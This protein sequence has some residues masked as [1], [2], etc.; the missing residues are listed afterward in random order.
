MSHKTI[1]TE[2]TDVDTTSMAEG[3]VLVQQSGVLQDDDTLTV[4]TS[5]GRLGVG[6]ASPGQT[7]DVRGGAVFNEDS[8]SVDFRVEGN[9]D[10]H[11][12]FVDGSADEVGIGVSNPSAKLNIR[13]NGTTSATICL[14]LEDGGGYDMLRVYNNRRLMIQQPSGQAQNNGSLLVFQNDNFSVTNSNENFHIGL[15][16]RS[17]GD[18]QVH[19]FGVTSPTTSFNTKTGGDLFVEAGSVSTNCS[20]ETDGGF[21]YLR[22]GRAAQDATN[23]GDSNIYFQTSSSAGASQRGT[24]TTAMFINN[25]QEVG[26]GTVTP[27]ESLDINGNARVR[28][29]GS[30]ASVGALHYTSNGTLT[31]NT[32][33][34]RLK[35][36]VQPL[37]DSLK[38]IKKLRGVSFDWI[39]DKDTSGTHIG[40]IAQEIEQVVPEV[41]F[42][43]PTD[44]YKGINYHELIPMLVESIKDQQNQ[45]SYLKGEITK[46][47]NQI[48][49]V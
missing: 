31:T 25:Q 23:L 34:E 21:L 28:S 36:N 49:N 20:S 19:R 40:F 41:V 30:G 6:T 48:N 42:E 5:N 4:D 2:F 18:H 10:T 26:I 29:I 37:T 11:L 27:T 46:L 43:N 24:W 3:Q 32:S 38:K 16:L 47:K 45:I 44:G 33:D 9:G 15:G 17:G 12:L 14:V 39:D 1:V 7:L 35:E 13:G 22:A 8:A